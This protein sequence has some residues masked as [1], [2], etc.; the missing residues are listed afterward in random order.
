MDEMMYFFD[1]SLTWAFMNGVFSMFGF[2]GWQM[3]EYKLNED[4]YKW[5][6]KKGDY[7]FGIIFIPLVFTFAAPYFW[8]AINHATWYNPG[9]SIV[10]G[11]LFDYVMIYAINRA[12]NKSKN[13][14]E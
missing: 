9:T 1:F 13:I 14:E 8:V 5:S 2:L 12:K 3:Y 4:G 10:G 6:E 11:L 7:L